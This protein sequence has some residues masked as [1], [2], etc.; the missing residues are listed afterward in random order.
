MTLYSDPRPAPRAE[1]VMELAVE[2]VELAVDLVV[3]GSGLK[4]LGLTPHM[5]AWAAAKSA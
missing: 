1:G 3:L 5:A 2:R 4:V